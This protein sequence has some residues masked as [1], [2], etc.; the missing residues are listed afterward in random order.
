M[1]NYRDGRPLTRARAGPKPPPNAT[2]PRLSAWESARPVGCGLVNLGNSCFLNAVIQALA[3]CPPL[4]NT[5]WDAPMVVGGGSGSPGGRQGGAAKA[6]AGG[7]PSGTAAGGAAGAAAPDVGSAHARL[8]PAFG[9][10]CGA[11]ACGQLYEDGGPGGLPPTSNRGGAAGVANGAASNGAHLAIGPA[12]TL[13][14]R[15]VPCAHCL[16]WSRV[17]RSLAPDTPHPDAPKE[18]WENLR[19][20]ISRT[21]T[22]GRQVRERKGVLSSLSQAARHS[23]LTRRHSTHA[24]FSHTHTHSSPITGGRPRVPAHTPGRGR[25]GPEAR[26]GRRGG[27]GAPPARVRLGI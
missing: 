8:F 20:T 4:A 24:L 18:L 22:P 11:P 16:L 10:P 7:G 2:T 17:R 23:V 5:V 19:A 3:H 6:G 13:A 27:R 1:G 9:G 25:P 21:L 26:A 14:R 15:P 12:S